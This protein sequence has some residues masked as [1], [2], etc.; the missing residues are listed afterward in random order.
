MLSAVALAA[1]M[2]VGSVPAA[3]AMEMEFNMLTGA[4]YNA[5]K[6]KGFDT[7]KIDQLT[8]SEIAEI[9]FLLSDGDMEGGGRQRI[10]LIL[11]K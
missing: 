10:N 1:S 4:V 6:S 7:D 3:Q 11:S 8:L 5:L 9:N 2:A